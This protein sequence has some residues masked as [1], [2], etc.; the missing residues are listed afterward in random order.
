[1]A[2][3]EL[4]RFCRPHGVLA[5]VAI[6]G[7]LAPWLTS[8][9]AQNSS[10][11]S[12]RFQF[13]ELDDKSLAVVDGDKTVL[14][15]NHGDIAFKQGRRNRTRSSYVHP[16]YGMDGEVLTDDY[17]ADHY[18]HHGLFWCWPH[19]K[20][21]DREYDFWER[22]DVD[23]NFKRWLA[24]EASADGAELAIE[25]GW[26]VDDKQVVKEEARLMVH[27]A[28][29]DGRSIDVT[30]T[31]TPIDEPITLSGAEGKSYGGLS[32]RFGPRKE[33]VVTVPGGRAG[34]D[35]LITKLPWA[36]LT[37]QFQG[38]PGPSGAAL[39][40]H[41][42]HPDFPPEW[43]TRDYG[44][45]AVGW[46]GVHPKTFEPGESVTCR[47]RIWIHRG[48]PD[49]DTLKRQYEAFAKLADAVSATE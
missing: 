33:T 7:A 36:D 35:L 25:N 28:T 43:M 29:A 16:I 19:V 34:E 12:A 32:L 17:P 11:S 30:L 39:F 31:W 40:V 13:K 2:V 5:V 38:A 42:S 22:D 3:L 9:R 46:P 14:V 23:I 4:G 41:P 8:A 15:Y 6:C 1:M 48:A 24:K 44:L 18:H 21:G 37:G 26:F 10:D 20:V 47:Y 49:A 27:P 45:L